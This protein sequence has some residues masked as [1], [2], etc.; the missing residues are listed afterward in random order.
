MSSSTL[1]DSVPDDIIE[2]DMLVSM[3]ERLT[4]ADETSRYSFSDEI[5]LL[6]QKLRSVLKSEPEE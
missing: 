2:A 3:I 4:R 1:Y 5:H 6:R